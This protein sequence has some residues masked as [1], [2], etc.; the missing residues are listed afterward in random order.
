MLL[1][2]HGI[3]FLGHILS[4]TGIKPLPLKTQ[5]INNMHS[6]K[7]AKQVHAFMGL[8]RYYR[9]FIKDFMK[10]AMPL[11]LLICHETKPRLMDSNTPYSIYGAEGSHHTG[12]YP[13]LPWH[14]TFKHTIHQE[15]WYTW[16]NHGGNHSRYYTKTLT[17]NRHEALLQMQ[18]I[19]PFCKSISK[20]LSNGKAPQHEADLFTHV[21]GL[22]C[23]HIMDANQI[24]LALII[25]KAWKYTV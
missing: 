4:T 3:Q 13:A 8:V 15:T 1:L 5:A 24:I 20:Q 21:K 11:T 12:P 19:D 22:L 16:L 10:M 18:R 17:A 7:T 9:T 25:P 14:R 2:H 6:L 23:K